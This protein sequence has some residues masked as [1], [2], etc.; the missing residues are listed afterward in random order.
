[1]VNI[2]NE[3]LKNNKNFDQSERQTFK[4]DIIK[5]NNY[6]TD[7]HLNI[8]DIN[9]EDKSNKKNRIEKIDIP[10]NVIEE[11]ENP[12]LCEICFDHDIKKDLA[13]KIPCGHIFCLNCVKTYIEKNIDNGKVKFLS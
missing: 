11:L 12:N 2:P 4:N 7:T 1:M 5:E 8:A 9:L 10:A 6:N 3:N 13:V